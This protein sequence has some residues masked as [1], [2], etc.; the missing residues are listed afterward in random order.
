MGLLGLNFTIF[1]L[2]LQEVYTEKN[3]CSLVWCTI[4][5]KV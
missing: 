4:R 5:A 3:V 1:K 2:D